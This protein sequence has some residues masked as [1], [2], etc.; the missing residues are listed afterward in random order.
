MPNFI[1]RPNSEK[2]QICSMSSILM[3]IAVLTS[4]NI[5]FYLNNLHFILIMSAD[6]LRSHN[7]TKRFDWPTVVLQLHS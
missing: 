2:S 1:N 3:Q 4:T 7:L 6:V 5:A